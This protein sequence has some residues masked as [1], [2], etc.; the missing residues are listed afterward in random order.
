MSRKN[1]GVATTARPPLSG[2]YTLVVDDDPYSRDI[3][4]LLLAYFGAS[5]TVATT[6]ATALTAMTRNLPDVVVADILFDGQEDG[7]W[8]PQEAHWRWP[9]LPFIAISGENFSADMLSG[10]GFLAF[11]R[12][13]VVHHALVDAVLNAVG[14]SSG[15][16]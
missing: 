15:N 16:S 11:L 13:P 2:L 12:K 7:L 8:L 3:L 14:R 10:A 4:R 6:P 5:V 1:E 9:R